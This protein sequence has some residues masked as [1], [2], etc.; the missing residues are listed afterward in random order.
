[1]AELEDA[2]DLGSRGVIPMQVR[3][4]SPALKNA[5]LGDMA[6]KCEAEIVGQES[7]TESTGNT[8]TTEGLEKRQVN[9]PPVL[10]TFKF[11][12]THGNSLGAQSSQRRTVRKEKV[13][14]FIRRF[15]CDLRVFANF[16]L[17]S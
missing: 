4:L 3:F 1:M 6:M 14:R 8:E 10:R 9:P 11:F 15:L 13:W 2:R 7:T 16:A 5:R 12:A 17:K